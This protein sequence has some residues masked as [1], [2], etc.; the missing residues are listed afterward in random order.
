MP[1][2]VPYIKPPAFLA[3]V[4]NPVVVRLGLGITLVVRG[5]TS[6]NL[7]RVP[8]GAPL[9]LDGARYLVSGR[10]NTHWVRN[11]RTAGTASLRHGG[12]SEAFRAV[13][14][15]GADQ[16]RVVEAYRAKLGRAGN[17]YFAEIPDP[18]DHPVFRIEPTQPVAAVR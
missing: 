16:V 7:L 5:R 18:H 4:V 10:G 6:G 1:T 11:L 14:L 17:S 9:E 8:I 3:K 15:T 2:A 12:R 13:E